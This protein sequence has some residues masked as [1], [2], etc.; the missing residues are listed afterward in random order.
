MAGWLGI[1]SA[2]YDSHCGDNDAQTVEEALDGTDYWQHAV[3]ETHWVILNLGATYNITKVR[4]RS[5]FSYDPTNVNIYVSTDRVTWGTAVATGISTWQDR[6]DWDG[7]AIIDTTPKEGRYIKVEII[8][9][10]D[11]NH[12]LQFGHSGPGFL[13]I[14]DVYG[15]SS[16]SGALKALT[17]GL[18]GSCLLDGGLV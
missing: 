16:G 13:K 3:N 7:T 6:D 14:F 5:L 17:S 10:E 18:M 4:G 11:A 15:S 1:S 2:H 12:T 8:D 9:T